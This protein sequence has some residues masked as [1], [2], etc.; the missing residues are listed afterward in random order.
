MLRHLWVLPAPW[1][2][3]AGHPAERARG[4][5]ARPG[6]GRQRGAA[7]VPAAG[8]L[9]R[10]QPQRRAARG[11]GGA[12][13]GGGRARR[14]GPVAAHPPEA[15]G[16]GAEPRH[17]RCA[18]GG[19]H[20]ADAVQLRGGRSHPAEQ[21][22]GLHRDAARGGGAVRGAGRHG[23]RPRGHPT[24]GDPLQVSALR[25]PGF[26]GAPVVRARGHRQR[27]HRQHCLRG[28]GRR[29]AG[30]AAGGSGRAA[31]AATGGRR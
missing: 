23:V 14:G 9:H 31:G 5:E 22:R 27:S 11:G 13:Q 19:V 16:D 25:T 20:E 26:R 24:G 6:P 28:K 30:G 2:P 21:E 4:G 1:P 15:G 29:G 18:R 17:G 12:R 8:A 7:G 10:Q 3:H